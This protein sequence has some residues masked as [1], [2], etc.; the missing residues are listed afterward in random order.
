VGG[1]KSRNPREETI[2][3]RFTKRESDRL[4]HSN[5]EDGSSQTLGLEN[6]RNKNMGIYDQAESN[7]KR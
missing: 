5:D 3:L 6:G 2:L 4:R 7:R 1:D